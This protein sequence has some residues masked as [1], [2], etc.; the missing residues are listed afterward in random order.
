MNRILIYFLLIFYIDQKQF[1]K[2]KHKIPF[3]NVKAFLQNRHYDS[4]IFQNN[5][6]R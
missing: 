6:Y 3:S 4:K 1:Y 2:R 5:T